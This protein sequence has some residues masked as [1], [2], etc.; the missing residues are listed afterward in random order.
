MMASV[1]SGVMCSYLCA[2]SKAGPPL[3][4]TPLRAPT[5]VPTMIAKD[6]E[7]NKLIKWTNVYTLENI[8]MCVVPVGVANK[9][10]SEIAKRKQRRKISIRLIDV[11][12]IIM[13]PYL[14]QAHKGS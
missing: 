1:R 14:V 3:I 5:E 8:T 10:A 2:I 7:R 6:V 9:R 11:Y 4:S 13:A 12:C